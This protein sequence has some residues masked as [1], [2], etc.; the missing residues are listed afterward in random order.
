MVRE[1]WIGWASPTGVPISP[2]NT[3]DTVRY[4][5]EHSGAGLLCV[6]KLDLWPQQAPGVPAAL[7]PL[8]LAPLPPGPS[9]PSS[10]EPPQAKAAAP[11][12]INP[13]SSVL[14]TTRLNLVVVRRLSACFDIESLLAVALGEPW[15]N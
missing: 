7:P 8:P 6:G 14:R 1:A 13:L 10:P 2:R 15:P 4:V 5:L 12:S 3:A 11:G 9:W